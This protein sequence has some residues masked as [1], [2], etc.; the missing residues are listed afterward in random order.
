LIKKILTNT[1]N[2]LGN[3]IEIKAHEYSS[4]WELMNEGVDNASI[5]VLELLKII[6]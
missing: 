4:F 5:Y 6:D 1:N 3:K 2:I